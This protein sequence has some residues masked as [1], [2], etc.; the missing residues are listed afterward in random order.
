MKS[1][2]LINSLERLIKN[3][4]NG[5]AEDVFLFISRITPVVNV[6]LLIK[7]KQGHTL[8]SW[9]DDGFHPVGWHI[10]GGILRYKEPIAARIKAVARN[11]LGAGVS[12]KQQPLAINEIIDPVRRLRG[13]FISLLFECR[14]TSALNKEL[15]YQQGLLQAGQWAWHKKC[16][17][18][19]ISV[20]KIYRKFI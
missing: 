8:L 14:L 6:D 15:Q 2:K 5:L 19:L 11:E 20:H 18:N 7:N 17:K 9:R 3:P 1:I 16:P 10:P 13:H 4:A 12:F